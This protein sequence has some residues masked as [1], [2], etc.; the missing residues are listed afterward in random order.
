MGVRAHAVQQFAGEEL[1]ASVHEGRKSEEEETY[2]ATSG[3][4]G[5]PE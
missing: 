3:D 1:N 5:E 2:R 4:A